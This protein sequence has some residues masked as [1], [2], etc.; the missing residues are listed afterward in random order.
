MPSLFLFSSRRSAAQPQPYRSSVYRDVAAQDSSIP[1]EWE[2]LPS[3]A[4]AV[5]ERRQMEL[6]EAA[7]GTPRGFTPSTFGSAW[8][9]T[10]R[11]DI[12]D[13]SQSQSFSEP[14]HGMAVREVHEPGVFSHFFGAISRLD[15]R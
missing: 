1:I 7:K 9:V 4:G 6:D 15:R 2:E 13:A 11:G 8:T 14:L 12:C 3:L 10:Q 5:A